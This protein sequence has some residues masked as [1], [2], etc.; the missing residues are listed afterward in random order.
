M[1]TVHSYIRSYEHFH[2]SYARML[3]VTLLALIVLLIGA[4]G[5]LLKATTFSAA[6]WEDN[7]SSIASV[8]TRVATLEQAYFNH[9]SKLTITGAKDAGLE[10][11]GAIVFVS[12]PEAK[13]ALRSLSFDVYESAQ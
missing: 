5:Y 7:E 10:E 6:A 1:S 8:S 2:A 4:Y 11:A 12:R 9:I 13:T 3:S